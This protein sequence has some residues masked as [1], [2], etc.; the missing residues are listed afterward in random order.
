MNPH[1][2]LYWNHPQVGLP[3]TCSPNVPITTGN[4]LDPPHLPS[5]PGASLSSV[6]VSSDP[7]QQLLCLLGWSAAAQQVGLMVGVWPIKQVSHIIYKCPVHY[8]RH[9]FMPRSDCGPELHLTSLLACSGLS[10]G[11]L[12][13][14]PLWIWWLEPVNVLPWSEPLCWPKGHHG[15]DLIHMSGFRHFLCLRIPDPMEGLGLST[16]VLLQFNLD[17]PWHLFLGAIFVRY[18]WMLLVSSVSLTL[19]NLLLH[20]ESRGAGQWLG[21]FMSWHQWHLNPPVANLY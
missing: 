11:H 2:V 14:P 1:L 6:N 20:R 9:L 8:P 17:Q 5:A 10:R 13:L 7:Y 3:H 16:F 12:I 4:A 18:S 15:V 19:T 21:P